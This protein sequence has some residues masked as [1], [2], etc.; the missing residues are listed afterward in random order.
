M[1][2]HEITPRNILSF[3]PDTKPIKLGKLNVLIGANGSGKSNLI[4]VISVL[5]A[6]PN[7]LTA[8]FRNGGGLEN[9]LWRGEHQAK[10]AS[11]ET[12]FSTKNHKKYDYYIEITHDLF[13]T[14]VKNETLQPEG[15]VYIFKR[16]DQS[17]SLY[18]NTVT[19]FVPNEKPDTSQSLMSHNSVYKLPKE[20]YNIPFTLSEINIYKHID[21]TRK[22]ETRS[23]FQLDLPRFSLLEDG[24]NI[25]LILS[26]I[27]LDQK[28]RQKY[29]ENLK[30]LYNSID[31]YKIDI[32]GGYGEI[33]L[34]EGR[35][36]I[37][38]TRLS[39]G[40]FRYMLL[41]AILCDPEPPSLICIEEPELGLHPD[42]IRSLG[43]LLI[44]A[45]ERTQIIVT[46][47]SDIL[48]DA[49]TD[50]PESVLV[51][52]KIDGQ[53]S[54]TPLNGEKLKPWLEE[55]RLGE[56]WTSGEIGGNRW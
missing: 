13:R 43:K 14:A 41:L 38:A 54:I 44:E 12:K 1:L 56:L 40:T 33:F 46:T 2:I 51:T 24:R 37:H 11:I 20:Y 16:K 9:W 17:I 48:V 25:V 55:Y 52:E 27:N 36:A 18:G 3:G 35:N 34:I 32:Y 21:S 4:D 26:K 15:E 53:T 7:D 23:R 29:I 8:P 45:S 39:D 49:M 50:Q 42:I 10:T 5:Q 22:T 31:D 6:L 28:S 30:N 47:H 19:D